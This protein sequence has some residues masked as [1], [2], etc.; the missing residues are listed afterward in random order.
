MSKKQKI[1]SAIVALVVAVFGGG[2][3]IMG[4][5]GGQMTIGPLYVVGD[6]ETTAQMPNSYTNAAT[7]T[8]DVTFVQDINIDGINNIRI[9]GVASGGTATSTFSIRPKISLNG[10]NFFPITGNST[11]T[12]TIGT[13]TLSII[14]LVWQFDPGTSLMYFSY[15]L[16]IPSAKTLRLQ[17]MGDNLATDPNDGIDAAIQISMEQ[18]Y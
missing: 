11:S 18:G 14:P 10:T 5:G 17:Y 7:V 15:E 9:S 6:S 1:I 3:A 16:S 4:G 12:D 13:T 2:A 8:T